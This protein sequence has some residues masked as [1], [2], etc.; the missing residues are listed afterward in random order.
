MAARRADGFVHR[1]AIEHEPVLC[2]ELLSLVAPKA[3]EVVVDATIGHGGHARLF[4]EAIGPTGH[5]IGLDVDPVNL[6]R[7]KDRLDQVGTAGSGPRID[8]I[9]ANFAE[10]EAVL[11]ALGVGQ[12]D[13]VLADLGVS[14]DQLLSGETGLSF[15]QDG[16]LDMRLD[17]RIPRSAA[18]LVNALSETDLADLIYQHAQ[19]RFSRRIAKRI[20]QVRRDGRIKTTSELARIVCSALG[21]SE[22]SHRSRIH[23]ATRTFLAL[24]IAVNAELENLRKLLASAAARLAIGGRVA[25]ISFH[26]GEDRIVKQDFLDRRGKGVYDIQTKKPIHASSEESA[27]NPRSRSAKLRVAVRIEGKDE[28]A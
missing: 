5:I 6:A 8:L 15:S 2:D 4:A 10:L 20:C 17:D 24:R 22:S 19:E 26:S 12:A 14:T 7:A 16:P 28:A 1:D 23:P 3:G 21:T 25:V 13:V 11:D 27:R 18:D 9:R